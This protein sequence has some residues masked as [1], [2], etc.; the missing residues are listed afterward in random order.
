M[1]LST[2]LFCIHYLV[3]P[4]A[5]TH[6]LAHWH[7]TNFNVMYFHYYSSRYSQHSPC[8]HLLTQT[9]HVTIFFA[10]ASTS[11][12]YSSNIRKRFSFYG[13]FVLAVRA[14]FFLFSFSSVLCSCVYVSMCCVSV[15]CLLFYFQFSFLF[16]LRLLFVSCFAV[17]Y[18]HC[19]CLLIALRCSCVPELAR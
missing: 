4:I 12:L 11:S 19:C 18:V 5:Y 15:V 14:V 7:S 6:T 13:T 10:L 17:V 9:M 8:T 2:T 1:D 16:I 3:I